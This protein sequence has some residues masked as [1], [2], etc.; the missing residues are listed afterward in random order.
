MPASIV[1]NLQDPRASVA[2][3]LG[4]AIVVVSI[5]QHM[6]PNIASIRVSDS[7]HDKDIESARRAAAWTSAGV[8]GF[9]FLLTHNKNAALI[10]GI[11]LAGLDYIVKHNNGFDPATGKLHSDTDDDIVSSSYENNVYP[12]SEYMDHA[13]GSGW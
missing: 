7:P 10:G 2:M 3:G 1:K 8:I 12:I 4:E 13:T 11:A 5:Y 6:L 9:L